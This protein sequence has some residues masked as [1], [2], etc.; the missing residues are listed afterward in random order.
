[1]TKTLI[2]GGSLVLPLGVQAGDLLLDAGKIEAIGSDLTQDSVDEVVDAEGCVVLPGLVD[3]HTHIQLDTG[4]YQTPDNWEIGTRTAACGGVT[5]V[6]DFATQFPRQ[7]VGQAWEARCA[8]IG[9][10]AQIDYGLHMMLTELPGDS[11]LE[12]W[13]AELV[14]LGLPAAKV[15]TTY[16]PNYFQDDAA[17]CRVLKAAGRQGVTVMTH[18]ENDAMVTAATGDLVTAGNTGLAY[19]GMARPA[20][21]EVEAA[22]RV[23]FLARAMGCPLYV[24]H[25][26]VSGTVNEVIDARERFGQAAMAETTPQYLLLDEDVYAGEHPERGI[27]QPPLRTA[28]EPARLWEQVRSGQIQTIG[29]DHCDYTLT[30]KL[31]SPKFTETPGGIPG[32][33]TMLPLLATYGV[34]GG[35]MSWL[36]LAQL[37]SSNP[38]R[39]F[40]LGH[41]GSLEVGLDA[42]VVIYDPRPARTIRAAELHGMAGYSPYEGMALTGRV[43]DVFSR[44]RQL[45]RNGEFHPAPG[46][47]R[48]V[49]GVI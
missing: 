7:D 48:F 14:R 43:R 3:P 18:C 28:A 41:K 9:Q 17:L 36:Q 45:V 8:E 10:R 34:A 32:L 33:E 5:T 23:L 38:A 15:Y 40:G 13:M 26:S 42:D 11:E 12:R 24:V 39:L 47:G 44:G 29:T 37:T 25:C 31:A 49:P 2:R 22:H 35:R 1:M 30:Q 46:W 16:R 4:L 27:M 20:L 21:A 6:I 19:H